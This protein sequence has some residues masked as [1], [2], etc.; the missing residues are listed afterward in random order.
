MK[1]DYKNVRFHEDGNI[2]EPNGYLNCLEILR[3]CKDELP[4][5][6]LQDSTLSNLEKLK[7]ITQERL[8]GV[9]HCVQNEFE[10]WKQMCIEIERMWANLNG[11]SKSSEYVYGFIGS[12]KEYSTVYYVDVIHDL[13]EC[14]NYDDSMCFEI[15]KCGG[16]YHS[17]VSKPV[18]E[19]IDKICEYAFKNK[20][21]GFTVDY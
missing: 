1:I 11:E 13:L 9:A 20:I 17:T 7:L 16:K 10:D 2:S 15:L 21:V 5:L 6:I 19:I 4:Q 3:K 14:V 8:W 18:R 12:Y